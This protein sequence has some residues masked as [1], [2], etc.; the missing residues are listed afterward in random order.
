M[1]LQ[2]DDETEL[3]NSVKLSESERQILDDDDKAN[4]DQ[5][6]TPNPAKA[7]PA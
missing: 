7:A 5:A 3:A 4:S 2:V 6:T 1:K